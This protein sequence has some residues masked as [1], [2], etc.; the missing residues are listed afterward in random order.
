MYIDIIVLEKN[1]KELSQHITV[2]KLQYIAQLKQWNKTLMKGVH[3][4]QINSDYSLVG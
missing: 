4:V 1:W 3:L 2:I